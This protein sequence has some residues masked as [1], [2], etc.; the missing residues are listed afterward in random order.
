MAGPG[1][2]NVEVPTAVER[3]HVAGDLVNEVAAFLV[4]DALVPE[5]GAPTGAE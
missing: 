2:H 3:H 4:E 1:A 5:V